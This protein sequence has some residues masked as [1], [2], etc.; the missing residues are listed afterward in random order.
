MALVWTRGRIGLH[1][2]EPP[3]TPESYILR[4][5]T[6]SLEAA[7]QDLRTGRARVR[8]YRSSERFRGPCSAVIEVVGN[9]WSLRIDTLR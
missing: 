6:H 8:E 2:E 7:L 3:E 9:T 5:T 1:E 4:I